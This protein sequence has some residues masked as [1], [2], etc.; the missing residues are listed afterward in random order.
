MSVA[1][2]KFDGL[3]TSSAVAIVASEECTEAT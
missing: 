1:L 3:L 2:A